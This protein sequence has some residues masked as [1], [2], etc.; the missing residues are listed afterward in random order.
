MDWIRAG[1]LA[2]ISLGVYL[3]F[4]FLLPWMFPFLA[5][6]FLVRLLQ[7]WIVVGGKYLHLKKQVSVLLFS[8]GLL[9]LF[10]CSAYRLIVSARREAG[11]SDFAESVCR[12]GGTAFGG[13]WETV[14][15]CLACLTDLLKVYWRKN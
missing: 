1:K 7:S 11:L 8:V 2:V 9:A 3:L 4:R 14:I 10:L 12:N 6:L 5:A 13:F 15:R